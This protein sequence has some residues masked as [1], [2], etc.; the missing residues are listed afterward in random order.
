MVTPAL[1]VGDRVLDRE[2]GEDADPAVV[3]ATGGRA[4]E[5]VLGGLDGN[6]TVADLNPSYS[7]HAA[8]VDVAFVPALD[9]ALDDWR[10]LDADALREQVADVDVRTYSYPEVRLRRV[11][12]EE[13]EA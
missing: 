7:S 9:R 11:P 5:V 3:V 2:S 10:D 4:D 6:P 13:V 12:R 1:C 8:V